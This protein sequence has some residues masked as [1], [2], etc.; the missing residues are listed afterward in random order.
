[1]RIAVLRAYGTAPLARLF[2]QL[3]HHDVLHV[4]VSDVGEAVVTSLVGGVCIQI[5]LTVSLLYLGRAVIDAD[6]PVSAVYRRLPHSAVL[7]F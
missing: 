4:L 6:A 5:H 7:V 3:V 1:M 2:V